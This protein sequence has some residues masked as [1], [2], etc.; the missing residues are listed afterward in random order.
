MPLTDRDRCRDHLLFSLQCLLLL[1]GQLLL[2]LTC[3][4]DVQTHIASLQILERHLLRADPR[5]EEMAR[6]NFLATQVGKVEAEAIF[7]VLKH[8]AHG[9]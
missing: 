4:A 3:F 6:M 9:Y 1:C 2:R 5:S 8:E 7:F